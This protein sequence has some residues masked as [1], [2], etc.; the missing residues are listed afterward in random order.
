MRIGLNIVR[1]TLRVPRTAPWLARV[2]QD[3]TRVP[4]Q[5]LH[6]TAAAQPS[7]VPHLPVSRG[8]IRPLSCQRLVI[9]QGFQGAMNNPCK[10]CIDGG[11][12]AVASDQ[13][14]S[15]LTRD[16]WREQPFSS[17]RGSEP[18][19]SGTLNRTATGRK[20]LQCHCLR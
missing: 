15:S 8:A 7:V 11:F 14:R 10:R 1:A 12:S 9:R 16:G 20:P 2:V 17:P 19:G 3:A 6:R 5:R 4:N 13:F 18:V